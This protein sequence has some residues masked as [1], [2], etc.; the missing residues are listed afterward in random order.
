METFSY[1]HMEQSLNNNI[2]FNLFQDIRN[3]LF[4]WILDD[5]YYLEFIVVITADGA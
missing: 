1:L 2:F 4:D 3:T 5:Y